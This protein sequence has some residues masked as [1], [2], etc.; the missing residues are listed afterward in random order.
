LI[1]GG[2]DNSVLAK[3][4]EVMPF[5]DRSIDLIVVSHPHADHLDGL[6]EVVKRYDV[7]AVIE[8]GVSHSIPEYVEWHNVLREKNIPVVIAKS[9][10]QIAV[11]G[12]VVMDVLL[13]F[14]NF[15]G[16]APKN[17][18][19]AT[20]VTRLVYASTS[21]LLTGDAEEKLEYQLLYSGVLIDSDILK[22]GHHG[23]KTSTSEEFLKAVS[24]D[25]AVISV[26]KKN[27]YGHPKQEVL[28]RLAAFGSRVFRTDLDGDI[29]L[30][31]D[32]VRF[33]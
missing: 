19:D 5:W 24:P 21:V 2:P 25:T 17:I 16:V 32:G 3:L 8:S 30:Q 12:G 18:H 6:L 4:G 29:L 14:E 28:D 26:G 1:D 20:V 33:E 22:V 9:G 31:S 11:G 23:S 10:Q 15:E 13:P 7:G 27:R